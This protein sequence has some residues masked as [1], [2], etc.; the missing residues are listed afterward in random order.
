MDSDAWVEIVGSLDDEAIGAVVEALTARDEG[1]L[2][3]ELAKEHGDRSWVVEADGA[4]EE[5]DYLDTAAEAARAYVDAGDWGEL[6]EFTSWVHVHVH[7]RYTVG[8]IY[9]D[10]LDERE[11]RRVA[12]EPEEP[13]ADDGHEHEWHSPHDRVGGCESSPGVHAHGGGVTI[14]EVCRH[15]DAERVTDTWAQDGA[16][17]GLR[18]VH[19]E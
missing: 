14:R 18:S 3:L 6:E 19:Y 16:V 13:E 15:C 7:P 12:I 11:L 8:G 4:E 2:A 9:V 1:E 17:Q 10:D 5:Y